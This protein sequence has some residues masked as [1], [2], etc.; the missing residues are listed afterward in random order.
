MQ[1]NPFSSAIRPALGGRRGA[2]AAAHPLAAA[3]GQRML[4]EGGGAVD[5]LIAAQA[6]L[7]VV[8]PDACGLGGDGLALV[9][10]PGAPPVAVHGAGPS[11]ARATHAATT[12]GAGVAVPGLVDAWAALQARWGRLPLAA[13]LAPAIEAAEDGL[14]LDPALAGARDRQRDRLLAGGAQ[15]WALMTL[16]AGGRLVQPALARLLRR[17]AAEGRAAFY[18]GET[19]S[20][21]ARAVQ[22]TGGALREDDLA[23]PAALV[24]PPLTIR[25]HDATLHVQPPPSQGVLLAMALRTWEAGGFGA[26]APLDHLGVELTQA[27][28]AFRDEATRGEALL[29]E[30]LAVDPDRASGRGGPRAYLHTAGVAAADAEGCVASS[31]VSVF[32]D[33]GS[34]VFVPEGGFTLNNRAGGFTGGANAFAPGRRPVHTLAPALVETQGRTVALSTPGADGQVQTLL[35]ILLHWL[36]RGRPLPD[37]VAA[38]RWRSEDGQLLVEAGHPARDDLAARGHAVVDTPAGDVRFGAVTAAGLWDGAPFALPDWRRT[39]WA[40]VA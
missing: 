39:T 6:V 32:D 16:A 17:I 28:F 14:R 5:A 10:A 35:Q 38:P 34:A 29:S 23:A 33:F 8:S 30:P 37:S 31:L 15:D 11:A 18:E 25:F 12:G 24:G 40:G 9:R 36:A 26:A 4:A 20:A 22:R 2:V 13:L 7:A 27:A 19:A 1:L 3:A 21:I